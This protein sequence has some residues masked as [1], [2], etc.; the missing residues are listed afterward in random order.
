MQKMTPAITPG[1]SVPSRSKN[2]TPRNQPITSSTGNA[3]MERAN[4]C[5]IGGTSGNTSF[6][7]IWLNPQ[8]RHS[9]SI[10]AIAPGV[11]ARPAEEI[12]LFDDIYPRGRPGAA[13]LLFLT[14]GA[15][16]C[17]LDDGEFWRESGRARRR[18][19]ALRHGGRG[20]FAN[21]TA[22][23]ADQERHHRGFVMIMRAGEEGVAALDSVN[24][25]V[26]HQ[27]IERAVDRD[28]RRPRHRLGEFVDHLIGAERAVAR[29]QRLQHL[30]PDWG[31][32]L[33]PPRADLLSMRHRFRSA[34]AVIVVGRGKCRLCQG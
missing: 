21:G 3:P 29:Q 4:A 27:K 26:L 23:I 7:A 16:A 24:E 33:R 8:L 15:G 12:T 19:E 20:N 1:H 6:T 22:M 30:A 5:S 28:R 31:E 17:D 34:A 10:N 25:A 18:V 13:F 2:L 14:V 9:I 11:S 32:F